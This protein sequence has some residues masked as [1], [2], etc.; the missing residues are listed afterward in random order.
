MQWLTARSV[1]KCAHDGRVEN[2]PRQHWVRVDGADVL[3]D[4]DP[5]GR[6][7]VAC[8]N[9]GPTIK[10]CANTLRVNAGYSTFVKI[11]GNSVVLSNLDGL[12]DGTPPGIVH[13]TLRDPMQTFVAAA[14]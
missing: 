4:S 9:F 6:R 3:V 5:V 13:Y 8:P 10:P 14:S 2:L 12:T 1:I 7:I 11:D